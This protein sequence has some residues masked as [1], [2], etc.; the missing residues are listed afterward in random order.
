V[1]IPTSVGF[2]MAIRRAALDRVGLFDE[3]AFGPGYGEENDFCMRARHAGWKHLLCGDV[4]VLHAGSTSFGAERE[5]RV[6]AAQRTLARMHPQYPALV[7]RHLARDPARPLRMRARL[8]VLVASE[9]PVVLLVAHASGG[10]TEKHLQE[11]AAHLADRMHAI[12]LRSEREGFVELCLGPEPSPDCLVFDV[13][14]GWDELLALLRA[15]GVRRVHLHHVLG[16]PDRLWRLAADLGVP[17]DVTLHDY[18]AING[19]PSLTD[20]AG[21]YVGNGADRDVRCAQ[22]CPLPRGVSAARWRELHGALLRG[23][24]RVFVPSRAAAALFAGAFDGLAI[25]VA[26][27]PDREARASYPE[28][29]ARAPE[30]GEP[31]RIAVL[32]ALGPEKGADLLESVACEARARGAPLAFTLIGYAYRSLH[33]AVRTTGPYDEA[34]LPAL[35]DRADPHLIWF[36]AQ[37]P[38]TYCYGLSR[39]LESGRP[40]LATDLGAL[41][42]RLAGRAW[43]WVEAWDQPLEAW[44]ARLARIRTELGSHA[45][46]RAP[47]TPE[48]WQSLPGSFRYREHYLSPVLRGRGGDPAEVD[49]MVRS[50]GASWGPRPLTLRERAALGLAEL[51][52]HPLFGRLARLVPPHVQKAIKRRLTSRPLPQ[53]RSSTQ[54]SSMSSAFRS[55]ENHS[56]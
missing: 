19:N 15:V 51:R 50:L 4:F 52:A 26:A 44:L 31:L 10:G 45:A 7:G 48:A 22:A 41:P 28:P 33:V 35:L 1:E 56:S 12:S 32:G 8:G 46:P 38:E 36:P 47:G 34:D 5:P 37:C 24:E 30:H 6:A 3:Q 2:C 20:R 43:S 13:A 25:T 17:Y 29:L 14:R 42:E 9:L 49:R 53:R 21:R 40:I 16:L 39:A 11:L 23:A 18:Y 27:H 54:A 55:S